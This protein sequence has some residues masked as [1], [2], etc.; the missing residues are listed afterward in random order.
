MRTTG[1]IS[2]RIS[3]VDLT[4]TRAEWEQRQKSGQQTFGNAV[5]RDTQRYVPLKDGPLRGSGSVENGG[6]QV[7]WESY[8]KRGY[9]Y[10]VRQFNVQFSNYTTSGTG[11]N[12]DKKAQGIHFQGWVSEVKGAL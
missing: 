8:S 4:L 10:G 3:E 7:S 6:K 11:P 5:L 1:L 2:M 12:W 9:P